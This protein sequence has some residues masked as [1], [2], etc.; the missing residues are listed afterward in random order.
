MMYDYYQI[1]RI[2]A[3][4]FFI[5]IAMAGLASP[6]DNMWMPWVQRHV[7][8]G[9]RLQN[10]EWKCIEVVL[11]KIKRN[12][13]RCIVER[14]GW[15]TRMLWMIRMSQKITIQSKSWDLENS[16]TR[17][18]WKVSPE[19]MQ[20]NLVREFLICLTRVVHSELDVRSREIILHMFQVNF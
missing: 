6:P 14:T 7:A 5:T 11:Q 3:R 19:K 1:L 13:K 17:S 4:H 16:C 20:I 9:I 10:I 18:L 2:Q 15:S 8:I 12:Q